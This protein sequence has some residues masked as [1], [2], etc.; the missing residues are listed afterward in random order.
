MHITQ[1]GKVCTEW[2]GEGEWHLLM[3]MC[4]VSTDTQVGGAYADRLLLQGKDVVVEELVQFL[5]GEVDAEL[6]K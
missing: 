5:I 1:Y 4:T 2:C 3:Y 6:L